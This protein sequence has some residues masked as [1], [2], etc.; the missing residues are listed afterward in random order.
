[1]AAAQDR[2][3]RALRLAGAAEKLHQHLGI[4][5]PPAER[6][7]Y[8][9]LLAST[10]AALGETASAALWA[11]GQALGEEQAVAYALAEQEPVTS[12]TVE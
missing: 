4:T 3:E 5:K 2:R 7:E 11:E 6:K 1:M 12:T 8:D 10:K 9:H